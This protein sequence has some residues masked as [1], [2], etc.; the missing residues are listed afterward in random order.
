MF[1]VFIFPSDARRLLRVGKYSAV[2][3][4][5]PSFSFPQGVTENFADEKTG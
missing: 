4:T 2:G 1:I 3:P 5:K